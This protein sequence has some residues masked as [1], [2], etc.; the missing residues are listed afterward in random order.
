M[1]PTQEEDQLTQEAPV[2][3]TGVVGAQ[4]QGNSAN[5]VAKDVHDSARVQRLEATSLSDPR[6]VELLLQVNMDPAHLSEE[7]R[8]TLKSILTSY[9]DVFALTNSELGTTQLVTHSIDTGNHSPIKQPLQR[10][11]FAFRATVDRLV[12]EMVDQRVVE[13]SKSLWA[14]PIVLVQKCDGGIRFCVDY[15]KLNRATKLDKFPLPRIDD[16][17][18][19]LTGSHH[20][21]TLTGRWRWSRHPKRKRHSQSLLDSINSGRC[22]LDLSMHQPH[23]K[24]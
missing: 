13:L 18:D 24:S 14:S 4:D 22:P 16:T 1:T 15:R 17:L 19:C 8:H 2:L 5:G 11:P 23:S 9:V 6:V 7:E 10:T 20:F 3:S 21:S 12:Q